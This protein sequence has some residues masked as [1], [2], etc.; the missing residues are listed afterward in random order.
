MNPKLSEA[1]AKVLRALRA[2]SR[3]VRTNRLNGWLF[4]PRVCV[5]FEKVYCATIDS[6][7]QHGWVTYD[8]RY[9]RMVTW[10]ITPAGL[11]ALAEYEKGG[12]A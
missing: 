5:L 1:Q 9:K 10:R 4:D 6:V 7:I 8:R 11:A 12:D 3:L 2:G